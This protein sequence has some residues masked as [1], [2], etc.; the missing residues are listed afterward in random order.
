VSRS[1]RNCS[2]VL[3]QFRQD[4]VRTARMDEGDE[5]AVGAGPRSPVDQFEPAPG[6]VVQNAGDVIDSVGHVVQA[7]PSPVEK[8]RNGRFRADRL[9]KF[10]ATAGRAEEDDIDALRRHRLGPG[11]AGAGN[12]FEC[13]QCGTDRRYCD[14]DVVERVFQV[15]LQSVRG[16]RCRPMIIANW[17]RAP[18][19]A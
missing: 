19:A 3:D 2:G 18:H 13:R 7:R 15:R 5:A 4:A 17:P 12:V 9:D 14:A 10:E 11:T 6:K 16:R 8:P 1:G